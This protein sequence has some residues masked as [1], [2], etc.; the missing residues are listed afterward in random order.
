MKRIKELR[1]IKKSKREIE[2][3]EGES[4]KDGDRKCVAFESAQ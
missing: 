1:E 2:K 3:K 4:K